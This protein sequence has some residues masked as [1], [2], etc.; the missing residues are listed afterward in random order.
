MQKEQLENRKQLDC[1]KVCLI[2]GGIGSPSLS[3]FKVDFNS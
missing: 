1:R 3:W 2:L